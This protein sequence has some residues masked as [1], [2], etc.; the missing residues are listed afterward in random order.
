MTGPPVPPE[1]YG[2]PSSEYQQPGCVR[3]PD[4]PTGLSCT[5][6]GRPACP[7][8]L[9]E[10][11]V[12]Y[13]CVDCVRA[14]QSDVRQ[15]VTP[16][17]AP[18]SARAIV[19]P[20]L[21]VVNALIFVLTVMQAGSVGNNTAATGFNAF[22]MFSPAVAAGEWWRLIGSGFLH[23]GPIHLAMNM[24]AL[25]VIGRDLEAV[26]GKLRFIAVYGLSLL[27]GSTAVYLFE[28]LGRSTAGASGAVFGLMGALAIVLFRLKLNPAPALGVIGINVVITFTV[29]GISWL[30][31]FGGLI[32]GAALT[33]ALVYAPRARRLAI[34]VGALVAMFVLLVGLIVVRDASL[35]FTQCLT[36]KDRISCR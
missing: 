36:T 14:G 32:V 30:G 11:S 23:I 20:T 5:R 19:V 33:A 35:P 12:G 10:A 13:Q 29:P 1:Q 17:G 16:A 15:P 2:G 25:W 24:L 27:G 4:R 9:R 26:L 34:Q 8:C 22:S 28:D 21:I 6:C 7:D 18:V 3:H 31:H